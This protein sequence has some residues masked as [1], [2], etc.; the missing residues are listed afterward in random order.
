MQSPTTSRKPRPPCPH[1]LRVRRGGQ[2]GRRRLLGSHQLGDSFLGM[3]STTF[4]RVMFMGTSRESEMIL[5]TANTSSFPN[6]CKSV[7][8]INSMPGGQVGGRGA[9]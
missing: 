5:A 2:G 1:H 3:T 6:T 4:S 9:G 8:D 7:F